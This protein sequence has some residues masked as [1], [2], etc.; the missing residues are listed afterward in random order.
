MSVIS[1]VRKPVGSA[2]G[3]RARRS[4]KARSESSWLAMKPSG[5]IPCFLAALSSRWR[6]RSR[7]ASSSNWTWLNRA[8]AFRTWAASWIGSRRRPREST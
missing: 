8:S 6:A 1:M 4:P 3:P 5:T 2:A 7:A